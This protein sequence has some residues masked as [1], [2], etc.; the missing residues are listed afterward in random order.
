MGHDFPLALW[1]YFDSDLDKW[2]KW[3]TVF[4]NQ[5]YMLLTHLI[6]LVAQVGW[7]SHSPLPP[8]CR[9]DCI[10]PSYIKLCVHTAS[11][12]LSPKSVPLTSMLFGLSAHLPVLCALSCSTTLPSAWLTSWISYKS[13]TRSS[14]WVSPSHSLASKPN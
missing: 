2:L 1:D 14:L 10:K 12:L 7:Y 6:V 9:D 11:S 13:K 8:H 4:N 3:K 5:S